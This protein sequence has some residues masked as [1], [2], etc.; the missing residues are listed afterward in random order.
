MTQHSADPKAQSTLLRSTSRG[1]LSQLSFRGGSSNTGLG[2]DV[3]GFPELS[4]NG[5]LWVKLGPV[6]HTG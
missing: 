2:M 6:V 1:L 4:P 3:I 5:C